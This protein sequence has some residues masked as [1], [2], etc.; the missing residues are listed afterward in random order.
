[1]LVKIENQPVAS[2]PRA[3]LFDDETLPTILQQAQK[4]PQKTKI[5]PNKRFLAKYS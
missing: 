3:K 4:D 2:A 5:N 1:M